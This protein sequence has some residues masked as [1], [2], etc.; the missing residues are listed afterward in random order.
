MILYLKPEDI[1]QYKSGIMLL[2]CVAE[3]E[4]VFPECDLSQE[5]LDDF[6]NNNTFY[7]DK[8]SEL[9]FSGD[10]DGTN[11]NCTCRYLSDKRIW[12]IIMH[13]T[14]PT[15]GV[16]CPLRNNHYCQPPILYDGEELEI[17]F[18]FACHV[19]RC[20]DAMLVVDLGNTRSCALVCDD[21]Q[22]I[23]HSSGIHL[24]RLPMEQYIGRN[25]TQND[26]DI[27]IFNS[28]VSFSQSESLF[29][30][31]RAGY[32]GLTISRILNRSDICP[33][34]IDYYLSSPKRFFW[35]SDCNSNRWKLLD[36]DI[37]FDGRSK[38]EDISDNTTAT[39]LAEKEGNCWMKD[40]KKDVQLSRSGILSSMLIEMMEQAETYLNSPVFYNRAAIPR[41]LSHVCI[42]FPA[43]WN[44][45]ER[46]LYKQVLQNA[47]DCYASRRCNK[48]QKISLDVSC[49]EATAVSMCY[50]YSE[51][52][53]FG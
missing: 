19:T 26:I 23:T 21:L 18:Q 49:D 48:Q 15:D 14:P 24:E 25:L 17:K 36:D 7:E 10:Y 53:K 40:N 8:D 52:D 1:E 31:T 9:E 11:L 13:F 46:D 41:L 20:A 38:G 3:L 43:A 5:Q 50:A 45:N 51:I 2:P 42:T 16:G 32:E 30:F 44:Q 37:E 28:Y 22:N 34:G 4:L 47:V 27:G 33:G 29:S 12:D 6:K 35:D 39:M